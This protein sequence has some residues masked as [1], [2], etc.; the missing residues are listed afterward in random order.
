MN[1]K[2][3]S[4]IT[5]F[6]LGSASLWAN[7]VLFW[8]DQV[9]NATRLSR[10]PPPIASLHLAT[11]HA[12]IFDAVNGF[13]RAYEPWLVDEVAPAGADR[14]AAI[15]SAAYTVLQAIWGNE[16]NP[17]VLR[18][19]YDEALAGIADGEAKTAGL[20]WGQYVAQRLLANRSDAGLNLPYAGAIMSNDVGK[21][22][23]TP[24]AFRP[25][26][27]P[28]VAHVRPFVMKSAAQFRAPPPLD[29]DSPE[30]AEQ[31]AFTAKVGARDDAERDEYQTLST[32]F[33]ADDL[34]TA[35]PAGHWNVIA[36]DVIKREGL[37]VTQSAHLL[38]LI[39]LAAADAGI[40]SWEAKFHY[41]HWRP[42]TALREA[43]SDLNAHIE[44][45]PEFIPNMASPAH[46]TYTSAHSTFTGAASRMLALYIGTDDF[47]FSAT[48]DGLPGVVRSYDS[49]SEACIELNMSRVWGGIHTMIDVV[50]GRRAGIKIADHVFAT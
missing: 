42:E 19:A 13:D 47:Q 22:R 28:A 15:A 1:R 41:L 9:L 21:W 37:D 16:V 30:Y 24:P 50:E 39:N 29:L 27:S 33:W 43:T 4:F 11:Y 45:K 40:S 12:A 14:D 3:I 34:G 8:N 31:L 48:S 26:V 2:F 5:L 46:P 44:A 35:T 10:N 32:P 49:F 25:P 6:C 23:E 7:P 38:A 17:R 18:K 36:Q 20:K